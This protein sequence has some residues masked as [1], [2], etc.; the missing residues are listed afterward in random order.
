MPNKFSFTKVK[1]NEI[2]AS[3]EYFFFFFFHWA[4]LFSGW[5]LLYALSVQ[6]LQ[7]VFT[8]LCFVCCFF[9]S[10]SFSIVSLWTTSCPFPPL[11]ML[12]LLTCS[13]CEHWSIQQLKFAVALSLTFLH[14]LDFMVSNFSLLLLPLSLYSSSCLFLGTVFLH[15]SVSLPSCSH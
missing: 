14:S 9:P 1:I 3:L 12:F 8:K 15:L 6:S 4:I 13:F 5:Y 10:R 7:S 2:P 11:M